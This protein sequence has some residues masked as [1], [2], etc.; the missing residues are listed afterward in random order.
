MILIFDTEAVFQ[1]CGKIP[2]SSQNIHIRLWVALFLQNGGK[3]EFKQDASG[4]IAGVCVFSDGSECNEW[5]YF[6][7]QCKPGDSLANGMPTATP[8][9]ATIGL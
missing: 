3:L 8:E 7:G 4:G 9:S 5:A 6:Q 1:W 2:D